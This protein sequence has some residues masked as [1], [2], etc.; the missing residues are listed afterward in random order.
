MKLI[1][2]KIA[3]DL[4]GLIKLNLDVLSGYKSAAEKLRD[5]NLKEVFIIYIQRLSEYVNELKKEETDWTG[6]KNNYIPQELILSKS[7][8]DEITILKAC[9]DLEEKS[10]KKYETLFDE[11]VPISIKEILLKQYN[12]IKE[13]QL[14]MRSLEDQYCFFPNILS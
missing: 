13:L 4:E 12:G 7:K 14:H 8:I 10:I 1:N 11:E 3:E 9:D 5:K 6:N 2:N